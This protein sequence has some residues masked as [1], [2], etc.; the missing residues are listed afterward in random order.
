M[1]PQNII[2][3]GICGSQ[4][5]GLANEDSD[6]DVKGIYV[7]PTTEVLSLPPFNPGETI[8][9]TD[10]DWTYHE[11]GKY[12]SLALKANPTVLEVLFLE[13]YTIQTKSGLFY[14]KDN[15]YLT[16]KYGLDQNTHTRTSYDGE[17]KSEYLFQNEVLNAIWTEAA[18]HVSR[19]AV[20][21][22]R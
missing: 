16:R 7:A 14:V 1:K 22:P 10:P 20:L 12:L 4:A 13:G 11:L 8:D 9:H 5:Y 6:Q 17:Y 2:L 18:R 19:A 3:E 21:V 15:S